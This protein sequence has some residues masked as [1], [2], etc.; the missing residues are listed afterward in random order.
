MTV[1]HPDIVTVGGGDST[2]W[3]GMRGHSVTL[4]GCR[5]YGPSQGGGKD[6]EL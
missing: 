1:E 4:V 5:G 2:V 6:I 3:G